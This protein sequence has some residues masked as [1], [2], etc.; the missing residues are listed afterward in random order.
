MLSGRANG[1]A[2]TE[3]RSLHLERGYLKKAYGSCL[4]ECGDTRV[5]CAVSIDDQLPAWRKG[6]GQG[7]LTAEYAMLPAAT[8][9]RGRRERPMVQGRSQE[10]QRLIGRSLRS[11][12]DLSILGEYNLTVDCDV[13]EAD[14]GTRC[15][16]ITGSW[17]ALAD[18]LAVWKNAG[19]L[20][21]NPL[22]GQV[23][24]V[25]VG[26][27]E[28]R[29]LLDMDY[30][31][32]SRAEIDMNLVMNQAGEFVEVQGTAERLPFDRGRLDQL[33]DLGQQGLNQL[34]AAQS[35]ALTAQ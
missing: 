8:V 32:D 12:L 3:L 28:G 1:R 31:E 33:L 11:V 10:I 29:L 4:V 23:A 24:A 2:D 34:L 20:K 5:L 21:G 35:K 7:W 14:G 22:V 16:A 13:I 27:M 15:A 25:S 18:A 30:H 19:K 17:L 26:M 9:P 6:S